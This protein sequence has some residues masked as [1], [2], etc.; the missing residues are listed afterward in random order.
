MAVSGLWDWLA[1]SVHFYRRH[2][3]AIA[4]MVLPFAIPFA[5][6]Q[7]M[8]VQNLP[9]ES[10][11]NYWMF[12]GLGLLM[13]PIYQGAIILYMRSHIKQQAWSISRCFE[14]AL[15]IWPSLFLVIA[16]TF[17]LVMLG[18]SFFVLPGIVIASRLIVADLHC[19]LHRTTPLQA[20]SASWKQTEEY[21][22]PLLAGVIIVAGV[23]MIPVWG[24]H[25]W[26]L[27]QQASEVLVFSNRVLGQILE[28]FFLVFAYRA[29]SAMNSESEAS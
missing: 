8:Y 14:A 19:V 25:R 18:L 2:F 3:M 6:I 9:E 4:L 16:M 13:Q 27:A 26:L 5:A 7:S 15:S 21:K 28:A 24:V 1:D 17:S 11:V 20:I 23:T 12:V 10:A 22:W 29:Y